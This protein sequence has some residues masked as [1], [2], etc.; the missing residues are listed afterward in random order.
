MYLIH[1]IV[2]F[3][4]SCFVLLQLFKYFDYFTSFVQMFIPSIMLIIAGSYY[5]N[6]YIDENG[7]RLSHYIYSKII[8]VV[9]KRLINLRSHP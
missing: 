3:S 1:L 6:K 2:I 5:M 7:I 9:E 8:R 4:F